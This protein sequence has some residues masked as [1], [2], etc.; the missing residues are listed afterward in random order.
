MTGPETFHYL[1]AAVQ[2]DIAV[3]LHRMAAVGLN[4]VSDLQAGHLAGKRA[5]TSGNPA[6]I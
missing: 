6:E 3:A 1:V 2:D 4:D 5:S